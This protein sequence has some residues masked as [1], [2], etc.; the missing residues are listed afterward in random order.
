MGYTHSWLRP[1]ELDREKFA[2]AAADCR[3][4]CEV[5]GVEL[6]G[7]EGGSHP[8]FANGIVAFDG[9]CEWFVIQCVCDDRSPERPCRD[10]PGMHFGYCKTEHQPYDKCVQACLVVLKHHLNA[11]FSVT[12]DGDETDWMPACSLCQSVLGYG[13]GFSLA[14]GT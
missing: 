3:R 6:R 4:I 5:S 2:A 12:S 9:G 7:I 8:V 13:S 11:D 10:K 14:Q 1:K